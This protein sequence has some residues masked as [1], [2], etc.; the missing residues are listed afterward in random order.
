M[1]TA[2][3]LTIKSIVMDWNV[4]HSTLVGIIM[5]I[6]R[7]DNQIA[8][9]CHFH[10]VVLWNVFHNRILGISTCLLSSLCRKWWTFILTDL[11]SYLMLQL[12]KPKLAMVVVI[13]P[14][15]KYIICPIVTE[16]QLLLGIAK[17]CWNWGWKLHFFVGSFCTLAMNHFLTARLCNGKIFVAVVSW[18]RHITT[19][20]DDTLEYFTSTLLYSYHLAAEPGLCRGLSFS[21]LSLF[22]IEN[23]GWLVPIRWI[24]CAFK[25]SNLT[26]LY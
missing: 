11:S 6:H 12:G 5:A 20:Y 13:R 16:V 3:I 9:C 26:M 19:L 4:H 10:S 25:G 22:S 1:T 7:K 21:C 18:L 14:F 8:L 15:S 23:T 17:G 2:T 24:F